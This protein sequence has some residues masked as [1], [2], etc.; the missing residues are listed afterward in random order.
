MCESHRACVQHDPPVIEPEALA[1]IV[2]CRARAE[3]LRVHA[4]RQEENLLL[5]HAFAIDKFRRDAVGDGGDQICAPVDETLELL[6]HCQ[7][8]PLVHDAERADRVG[9]QIRDVQNPG[10]PPGARREPSGEA[11]KEWRR[12]DEDD[13]GSLRADEANCTRA[14]KRQIADE[15]AEPGA[16]RHVQPDAVDGEPTVVLA[17]VEATPVAVEDPP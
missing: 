13:V 7:R 15:S 1:H 10:A 9:P 8:E 11:E 2:V 5:R 14:C 17:A 4:I 6:C 16:E 12:L 3:E